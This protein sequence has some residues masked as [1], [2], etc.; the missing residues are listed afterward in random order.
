MMKMVEFIVMS[1]KFKVMVGLCLCWLVN[2]FMMMLFSGCIR[3]FILKVV[4]DIISEVYFE[5]LGKNW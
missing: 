3:K 5:V 1:Y 4:S 2:C